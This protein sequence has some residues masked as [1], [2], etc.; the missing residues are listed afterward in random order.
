M[1]FLAKSD[2]EVF[3][4]IQKEAHRQEETIELIASEN[5]VSQAVL[6]ANGSEL[7]NKYAEGYPGRRYYGGCEF[8]DHIEALAISRACKLFDAEHANVQPHS[9][10]S[11]NLAAYMALIQPG[12]SVLGMRLDQGGHLTHGAKVN[13]SGKLYNVSSYGVSPVNGLIEYDELE[14]TAKQTQPK[15]IIA[16]ASAYSRTIDFERIAR[17]ARGCGAFF[18]VDMAHIAGLVAA[19]LHPSPIPHADVV[20][21]TTHKTL[22][23]I[24]GGFILCKEE[25]AKKIDSAVFPGIQGGPLM[26]SIAAKAVTFGEALLP[27]FR[28]YQLQVVANAQSLARA[29]IE[30][31]FEL[32]SGGTDNHLMLV[33]VRTKAD[34]GMQAEEVLGRAGIIVNKNKI[35]Y[36]PQPANLGSGIRLGTAAVTTRGMKA[37]EMIILADFIS[38]ALENKNNT[39]QIAALKQQVKLFLK[40]FPLPYTA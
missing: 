33:D 3:S 28:D 31:G 29:L 16:G 10:A 20:T 13:F 14:K 22:R 19:G 39:E 25:F 17:I 38:Q 26:H 30:R 1:S 12:E 6:E 36:D 40:K 21:S 35:P 37:R 7:T 2:P 15:L 23:G 8:V 24:R 5:F 34:S 11:A 27:E 18:M 32:V 4:W 9:G